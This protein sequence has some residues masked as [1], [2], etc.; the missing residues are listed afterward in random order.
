VPLLAKRAEQGKSFFSNR[1]LLAY[2]RLKKA[3]KVEKGK[4]KN[5]ENPPAG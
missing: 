4:R 1:L 3:K 5:Q 2:K